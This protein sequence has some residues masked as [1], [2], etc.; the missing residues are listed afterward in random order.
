[1]DYEKVTRGYDYSWR[2]ANRGK[3]STGSGLGI[4]LV[5]ANGVPSIKDLW[6]KHQTTPQQ[7]CFSPREE[8]MPQVRPPRRCAC[9]LRRFRRDRRAMICL[10]IIA[11]HRCQLASSHYL[12]AHWPDH[13]G[14]TPTLPD[15]AANLSHYDSP[16]ANHYG[17]AAQAAYPL[18]TD[19][20]GRDILARL[21]AGVQV[22][23]LVTIVVVTFDVILGL[24]VGT[25]AGFYGGWMIPSWRASPT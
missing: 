18:G 8:Q 22:S 19:Q 10:G 24:I 16:R 11:L 6:P 21:M 23:I 15:R 5:P 2:G 1:M 3:D 14:R 20:L 25:L 4:P 7:S 17:S 12:P 9:P 13:H